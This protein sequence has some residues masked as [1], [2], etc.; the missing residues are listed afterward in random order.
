MNPEERNETVNTKNK[1]RK[2]NYLLWNF[3]D[4]I[5]ALN[6]IKR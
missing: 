4:I 2:R 3:K 5:R 1:E 6:K